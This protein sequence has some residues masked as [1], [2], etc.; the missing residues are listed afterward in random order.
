MAFQRVAP[1]DSLWSGEMQGV[2]VDGRPVLLVHVGDTI[3]AFRDQCLHLAV[4]LSEGR[5]K[6]R[7]LVCSAHEWEYDACTGRGENPTG[8]Q[9]EQ[10]AVRVDDGGIWVDVESVITPERRRT[11]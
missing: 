7:S 8:I 10:Y 3:S 4:P 11:P 6:G 9:L 5:L 1:L 2:V